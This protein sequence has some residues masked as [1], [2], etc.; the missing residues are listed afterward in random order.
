M[1]VILNAKGTSQSNFRIGKR[2]A[3]IYGTSDAPSDVSQIST[4]DLW[5]DS[6]NTLLKIATVSGGSVSWDKLTVG[7][8]DTLDGI[9]STVFARTDQDV[10]FSEDITVSGNLTVSGTTTT[11]NTQELNIADN[12]IVLNSDLPSNQP[13]T[14]NAGILINR[15]N[16]SNV[17][18]RW[19]EGEGEWT[20]NGQTFSAGSFV[21]NLSGNVTGSIAPN[22]APN[23]VRANTLIVTGAT[24]TAK[25][26]DNAKANFGAGDD[27][28]IYHDGTNSYI[29]DAGTG[30]IFLRSGTTYIQNAAGSKTAIATNSG[31]A[32]QIYHNNSLK[33]ATSATGITVTGTV[34]V[35]GAYTLPTADGTSGQVLKTDGSGAITFGGI[36]AGGSNTHVQFNDS[37]SLN[38]ESSFTYDKATDKLTVKNLDVTGVLSRVQDYG[39]ITDSVS[40]SETFD[41]GTVTGDGRDPVRHDSYTVTEANNLSGL[42]AGDM[43]FVS[44]E[45]GGATMA[46][47]D[48]T[49]WRR[50]QD[51]AVIS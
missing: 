24:A 35:N 16:E 12:E 9:N 21:G 19:D 14:A 20:V 36:P 47:Y 22:G 23:T 51:R 33:L 37:G 40:S 31:G 34:D 50:I 46:F 13:A 41:Y 39:A 17:Y 49:N 3:R 43:I 44:N 7:D 45:T 27:L 8:A 38:G 28:Q 11:V 48:G 25:F 26:G 18:I 15:G 29:D 2:G 10:T 6:S 4:G 1:A 42:Q 30:S 32:Q 5:F